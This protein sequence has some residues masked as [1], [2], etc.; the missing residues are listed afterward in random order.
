[1]STEPEHEQYGEASPDAG[2]A[3]TPE[4]TVS[5]RA[6]LLAAGIVGLGA[7]GVGGGLLYANW[8]L[9]DD[10]DDETDD[11]D[12]DEPV[13]AET[14][15]PEETPTP[16]QTPT[17]EPTPT[18]DATP[19]PSPVPI[20]DEPV[21]G[22]VLS[23]AIPADPFSLHPNADESTT[24]WIVMSQIY[25][26]LM[27][28][29][30]EFEVSPDL[31]ESYEIAEDGSSITFQIREDAVFHNGEALTAHDITYTHAWMRVPEQGAGRS[32]YYERVEQIDAPDDY[33]VVFTFSGPDGTFLRRAASTF[34]V[35]ASHH[36][37][38]GSNG[39]SLEP[40]G[41][42]PFRLDSWNRDQSLQLERF[43]A[44]YGEQP[45]LDGV[46]FQIIV[47][48]TDRLS[49]FDAGSVDIIYDLPV[50][51]ALE[52]LESA[53][54]QTVEVVNLDCSQIILNT[55]HPILESANVRRAILYSIDRPALVDAVYDGAAT[56]ATSYLSPA[57]EFWHEAMIEADRP[58][59][60]RASELL[61]EAG[62]VDGENGIRER[63]GE[64]LS[65]TCAAP[66]NDPRLEGAE[67]ISEMLADV[68][69]E[70]NVDPMAAGAAVEQMRAGELDAA[71]FNWTHGGIHGEPDGRT[72]LQTGGFNN[73]SQYSSVQ[74]DNLLNQGIGEVDQESRRAI[75]RAIQERMASEAPIVF[76]MFPHS[77]YHFSVRVQGV[78]ESANW[79]SR[80]FRL[81][82][83][84]WLFE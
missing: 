45:N 29:D 37:E 21:E 82:R 84:L 15:E 48:A 42:G 25:S 55:D 57:L 70:M 8:P 33:T 13:P 60:E 64:R 49:A 77:F 28:V 7:V 26:S 24:N 52:Q 31:T 11:D 40:I 20:P 74:L 56:P 69:I 44:F 53:N 4:P 68:G 27:A 34:I 78:P 19:T 6:L 12:P 58:L 36:D 46:Q 63:D 35:N 51:L 22:G 75:Y 18:P 3:G 5:R 2:P 67:M 32:F 76:L 65:F 81:A 66:E 43:D 54:A 30:H 38:I 1:M 9:D 72:S 39:Y 59:V 79:G 41:S 62:W 80:L 17:P 73:F 23:I 50:N 83:E 14:P 10:E 71:L 61:Q 16:E 47:D